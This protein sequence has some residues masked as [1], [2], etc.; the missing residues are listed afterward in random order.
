M[1][2]QTNI[3]AVDLREGGVLLRPIQDE[4]LLHLHL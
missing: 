4:G 2:N 3:L 1:T